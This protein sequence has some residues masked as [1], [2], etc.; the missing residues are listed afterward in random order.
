M[1]GANV[2]LRSQIG[3]ARAKEALEIEHEIGKPII[4]SEDVH[5]GINAF[6]ERRIANFE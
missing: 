3:T 4:L 1:M 2:F 6:K 5:E